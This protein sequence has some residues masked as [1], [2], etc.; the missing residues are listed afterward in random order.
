[1]LSPATKI[2][3]FILGHKEVITLFVVDI[4]HGITF[5]LHTTQWVCRSLYFLLQ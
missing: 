1:M 3:I 2:I 4:S 5:K